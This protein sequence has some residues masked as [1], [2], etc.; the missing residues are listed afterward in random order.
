MQQDYEQQM[1]NSETLA[2]DNSEKMAQLKVWDTHTYHYVI[3]EL[4]YLQLK[5]DEVS[6]LKQELTRIGKIRENLQRR[7]RNVEESKA[8]VERFRDTL[9]Q[10][11]TTL[12]RGL[13]F[14]AMLCGDWCCFY[15]KLRTT[16]SKQKL[17]RRHMMTCCEKETYLAR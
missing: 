4:S 12:E 9:K 11:I 15:K 7:L 17:K 5:E 3:L 14:I 1:M 2:Q 16:R 13:N 8:E 10:T 6:N